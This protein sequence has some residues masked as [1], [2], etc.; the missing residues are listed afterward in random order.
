MSPFS[1]AYNNNDPFYGEPFS[2]SP[3]PYRDNEPFY[4]EPFSLSPSPERY[5]R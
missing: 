1:P 5:F 4:G 3:S 2:L